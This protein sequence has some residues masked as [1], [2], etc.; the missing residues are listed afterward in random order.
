MW[1]HLGTDLID[2]LVGLYEMG[3]A[4]KSGKLTHN[5][6]ENQ[7]VIYARHIKDDV[8]LAILRNERSKG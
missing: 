6:D 1:N 7:S 4:K 2:I 8:T 5:G 3:L